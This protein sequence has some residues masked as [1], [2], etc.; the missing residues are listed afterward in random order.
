M[1]NMNNTNLLAQAL[2]AWE[3]GGAVQ[4]GFKA[5]LNDNALS[6]RAEALMASGRGVKTASPVGAKYSL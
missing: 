5:T 3:V 1:G 2:E 6:A 4:H